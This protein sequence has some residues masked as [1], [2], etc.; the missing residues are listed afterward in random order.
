M[1]AGTS[2]HIRTHHVSRY[3][4]CRPLRYVVWIERGIL[5]GGSG[6]P[7]ADGRGGCLPAIGGAEF[8]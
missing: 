2:V 8:A 4:V 5:W 7:E 3:V 6:Q 1:G